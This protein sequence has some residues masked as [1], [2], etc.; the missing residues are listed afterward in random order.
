MADLTAPE[1]RYGYA[2]PDELSTVVRP[3]AE[4]RV[5]R[6]SADLG[7]WPAECAAAER[8]EPFTYV[9][10]TEGWLR[11]AARRSEHVACAAGGDVL[12]AG[13]MAFECGPGGWS[14]VEIPALCAARRAQWA[15][16]AI[17]RDGDFGCA[18]RGSDLPAHWNLAP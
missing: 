2:G 16:C 17:V 9:V 1:R 13:K 10:G 8:D 11:L 7:A 6:S 4:G 14:A 3:E 5:V 15:D 18:F 12:G